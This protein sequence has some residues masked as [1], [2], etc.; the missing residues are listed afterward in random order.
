MATAGPICWSPTCG[1]RR[2][3]RIV[4]DPAFGPAKQDPALREAYRSHVKG[5]SLYHNNGD[6]TFTYTG[7]SQGIEIW[8]MVMGLRRFR[9]R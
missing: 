8:P 7:D 1:A 6:G 3:Q 4:N 5:N 2:G 9:L